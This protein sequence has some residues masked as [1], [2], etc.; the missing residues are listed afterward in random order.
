MFFSDTHETC[1]TA[2]CMQYQYWQGSFEDK[3]EKHNMLSLQRQ[4]SN[5]KVLTQ[6]L[7]ANRP[8][9]GGCINYRLILGSV[10]N[11]PFYPENRTDYMNKKSHRSST[12]RCERKINYGKLYR[13]RPN[14]V[15]KVLRVNVQ[16]LQ[17]YLRENGWANN[18]FKS[19]FFIEAI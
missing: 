8:P 10:L 7:L 6:I 12:I 11:T 15:Q 13:C 3:L 17:I 5:G 4:I 1:A 18:D 14:D 9:H 19:Y 2:N 16:F